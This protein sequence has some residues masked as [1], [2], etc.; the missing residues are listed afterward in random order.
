MIRALPTRKGDKSTANSRPVFS[1]AFRCSYK[2]MGEE[3]SYNYQ[4]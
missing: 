3:M 2:P 4:F 1:F